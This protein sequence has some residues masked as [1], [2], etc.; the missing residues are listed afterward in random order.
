MPI[1]TEDPNSRTRLKAWTM[2]Y[3]LMREHPNARIVTTGASLSDVADEEGE[4]WN[5]IYDERANKIE[6]IF[7]W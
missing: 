6:L 2:L 1:P 5:V 3:Q 7:E 4:L